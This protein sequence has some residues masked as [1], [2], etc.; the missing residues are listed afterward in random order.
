MKA[1]GQITKVTE[2]PVKTKWGMKDKYWITLDGK[3]YGGWGN[4]PWKEGQDVEFE[5]EEREVEIDQ[6]DEISGGTF[7]KKVT[8]LD[9]KN[10]KTPQAFVQSVDT[11]GTIGKL[12]EQMNMP[13][14]HVGR[15]EKS[16]DYNK[17]EY[18]VNVTIPAKNP[19]DITVEQIIQL[20]DMLAKAT[21]DRKEKDEES[22]N[23]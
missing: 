3:S 21:K 22:D 23:E 1:H 18:N 7:K 13:K 9:I 2:K 17:Y 6:V 20:Q 8:F 14:L 10:P 16:G 19:L 4:C 15:T 11:S 5:Y 12:I